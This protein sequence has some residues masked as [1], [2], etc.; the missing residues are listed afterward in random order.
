MTALQVGQVYRLP[1]LGLVEILEVSSSLPFGGA[2]VI[3]RALEGGEGML[4][5]VN[6]FIAQL[7][8]QPGESITLKDG[9]VVEI[10]E[11]KGGMVKVCRQQIGHNVTH[12]WSEDRFRSVIAE[13]SP[14]LLQ[15]EE[16][17]AA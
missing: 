8:F 13:R 15:S 7:P 12:W 17:G 6:Q 16:G 1:N 3:F 14:L 2:V 11:L 4:L 10:V 9:R 5:T